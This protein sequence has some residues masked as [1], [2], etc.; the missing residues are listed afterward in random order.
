MRSLLNYLPYVS[1]A[2]LAL[3]LDM[4]RTQC[5]PVLDVPCAPRVSCPACSRASLASYPT[6]RR[7]LRVLCLACPRALSAFMPHVLSRLTIPACRVSW[8]F[9]IPIS[10]S[11]L[12]CFHTL[13]YCFIYFQLVSFFLEI[14]YIWNRDRIQVCFEVTVNMIWSFDQYNLWNSFS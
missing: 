2:R 7:A 4:S 1:R 3:M 14:L 13:R 11:L 12:L 8:M 10:S 6:C 5:A 9:Y